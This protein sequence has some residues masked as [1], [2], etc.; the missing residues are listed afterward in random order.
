MHFVLTDNLEGASAPEGVSTI[1][2]EQGTFEDNYCESVLEL[3]V[4]ATRF[5]GGSFLRDSTFHNNQATRI[6]TVN[7]DSASLNARSVPP[8]SFE[9]CNFDNNTATTIAEFN[10]NGASIALETC[11]FRNNT[12]T[13]LKVANG[14]ITTLS[15][16]GFTGNIREAGGGSMIDVTSSQLVMDSSF[17]QE[18]DYSGSGLQDSIVDIR[19]SA[20]AEAL[21]STS[22]SCQNC[23][24][25]GNKVT[26]EVVAISSYQNADFS[27]SSFTGNVAQN[28][29][30]KTT[31]NE[32]FTCQ[33]CIFSENL[34]TLQAQESNKAIVFL[35]GNGQLEQCLFDNNA[36]QRAIVMMSSTESSGFVVDSCFVN[37]T[38]TGDSILMYGYEP[39]SQVVNIVTQTNFVNNNILANTVSGCNGLLTG[40][41]SGAGTCQ[42]IVGAS[43]NANFLQ[44]SV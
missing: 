39:S 21:L 13:I 40:T 38:I 22:A 41:V 18:N 23:L 35:Q 4:D 32:L 11:N 8:Y 3:S 43:C 44:S 42:E 34:Q 10:N 5:A 16:T 1:G 33:K 37:N 25:E 12:G 6:I 14:T 7:E 31:F 26:S 28:S 15:F 24:F 30:V 2:I 36:F 20:S 9:R 19:S 27:G 29:I 17:F